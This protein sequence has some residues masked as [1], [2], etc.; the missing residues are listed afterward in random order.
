MQDVSGGRP[1]PV[2][3]ESSGLLWG[4]E[5]DTGAAAQ[6][7]RGLGK[8]D[9]AERINGFLSSIGLGAF[10]DQLKDLQLG[11]CLPGVL[12]AVAWVSALAKARHHVGEHRVER[13]G[14]WCCHR[15][16][17]ST[18][19]HSARSAPCSGS[20]AHLLQ[21]GSPASRL[22]S[23]LHLCP[24]AAVAASAAQAHGAEGSEHLPARH[25]HESSPAG[26]CACAR[27]TLCLPSKC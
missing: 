12:V 21:D 26:R 19:V 5:M 1:V 15:H 14:L 25:G 4:M 11:A 13:A 10:A 9:N 8:D 16:L 18:S 2:A 23:W 24:A 22:D 7:L 20:M 27:C 3:A 17:V 6:E